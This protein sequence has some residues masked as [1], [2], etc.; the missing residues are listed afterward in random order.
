MAPVSTFRV[1]RAVRLSKASCKRQVGV[2][3]GG[4]QLCAGNK[5]G[6][7]HLITEMCRKVQLMGKGLCSGHGPGTQSAWAQRQRVLPL[8]GEG[9][10]YKRSEVRSER[11]GCGL[12]GLFCSASKAV[13]TG[14]LSCVGTS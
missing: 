7:D 5:E 9:G 1:T 6:Q 13:G 8:E 2:G 12:K 10:G 4:G 11:R 3:A 14:R